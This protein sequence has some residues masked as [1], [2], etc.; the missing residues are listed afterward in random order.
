ERREDVMQYIYQRYGRHRAGIAATV[1]HYRPR[2]AVRE[3]GKALGLTEDITGRIVDTIWGSFSR[4][5]PEHRV[6]EAG[7][8][9]ESPEI[10]RLV[11]LVGQLLG[12]K[13][14][15]HLSQHVGG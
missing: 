7:F 10:R 2:S 13:A 14:P 1:I 9:L 4:E 5:L 8:D 11:D 15:R 6:S 12:Q 3:V